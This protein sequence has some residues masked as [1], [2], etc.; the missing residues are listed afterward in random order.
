MRI[1]LARIIVPDTQDWDT[2]VKNGRV[3]VFIKSAR[4]LYQVRNGMIYE[5][6]PDRTRTTVLHVV[7]D[8]GHMTSERDRIARNPEKPQSEYLPPESTMPLGLKG[9]SAS[10]VVQGSIS[11]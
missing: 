6:R 8:S 2:E 11:A 1:T 7:S 4:V 3:N 9:R 5:V 10:F